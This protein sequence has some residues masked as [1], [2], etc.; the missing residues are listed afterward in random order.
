MNVWEILFPW[1]LQILERGNFGSECLDILNFGSHFGKSKFRRIEI[2]GSSNFG[3]CEF[4]KIRVSRTANFK[5]SKFSGCRFEILGRLNFG[6]PGFRGWKNK[7]KSNFP[8]VG[9]KF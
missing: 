8:V 1:K 3:Y 2:L 4:W 5:E 6:K 7:K 9:L